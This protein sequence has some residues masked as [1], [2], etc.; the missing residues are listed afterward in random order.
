MADKKEGWLKRRWRRGVTD[1][2][3]TGE[4]V[5]EK[6]RGAKNVFISPIITFLVI[7]LIIGIA[8]VILIFIIR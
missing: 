2:R 7:I 1:T 8:L 5:G 3:T 4:K 6:F